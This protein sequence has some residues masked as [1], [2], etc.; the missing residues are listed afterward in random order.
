M[1]YLQRK[2]S[3]IWPEIFLKKY[4]NIYNT[5]SFFKFQNI[6]F[7]NIKIVCRFHLYKTHIFSIHIECHTQ[8]HTE[9]DVIHF[10]NGALRTVTNITKSKVNWKKEF[11]HSCISMILFIDTDNFLKCKFLRRYFPRI[12]L[13]DSELPT[14]KIYFFEVFFFKFVDIFQNSYQSKN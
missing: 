10:K 4:Q 12:L 8:I 9:V 11:L 13:I 7:R 3:L 14:L 6:S 1:D 2:H 5:C